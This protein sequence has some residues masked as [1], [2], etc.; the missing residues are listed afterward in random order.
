ME[1]G[2][3]LWSTNIDLIDRAIQ[4]IEEHIFE[5]IELFVVPGS[6]INPFTIDVPYTIHA[7]HEKFG[8]NIGDRSRKHTTR[9][10]LESVKWADQLNADHIILHAGHGTMENAQNLLNDI[11]DKRF[12]I[13]NMP[14][15]GIS[16][17]KMI[18]YTPEQIKELI[19]NNGMG[20]CLDF[21]HAIKASNSLGRDYKEYINTFLEMNPKMF[22]ISDGT[23]NKEKDEH[24]SIG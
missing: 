1:F 10:I 11:S 12:L 7:P 5:Y 2:L 13:E 22:H 15:V 14:K 6:S 17:E 8:T 21:G 19:E 24:L 4:L 9:N 18:G 23:L 16:D 3:K 20:V